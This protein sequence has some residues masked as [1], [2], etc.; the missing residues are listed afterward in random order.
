MMSVVCYCGSC[1]AGSRQIDAL[2]NAVPIL[3]PDAGTAYVLYRK[4]R[5]HYAKGAEHRRGYTIDEKSTTSRVVVTCCSSAMVMRFDDAKDW[6]PLYRGRFQGDVPPVKWRI[7]T[8]FKPENAEV[9]TD[10]PSS[11]MYPA[12]FMWELLTSKVAMLFNRYVKP[13]PVLVS[14]GE[15][16]RQSSLA[17][18]A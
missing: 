11:T 5:I 9:P 1:Q 16:G 8:K 18:A 3:G 13:A 17:R 14:S 6:G 2:T 12:G 7:C 10:V 4:D 15:S